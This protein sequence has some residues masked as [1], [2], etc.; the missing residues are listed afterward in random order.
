MM[1]WLYRYIFRGIGIVFLVGLITLLFLM[2]RQ[3]RQ[4]AGAPAASQHQVSGEK[5]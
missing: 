2:V 1:Q 5:Q 4:M 3:F